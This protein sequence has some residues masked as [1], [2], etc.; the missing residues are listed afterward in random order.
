VK[1]KLLALAVSGVI[2]AGCNNDTNIKPNV[3][4]QAWDPAVYLMNAEANCTDG[5]IETGKTDFSGNAAFYSSTI[6]NSPET[7]SFTFTGDANS[8]DVSNGKSMD[9][10]TYVL[11]KGLAAAGAPITASPLTTLINTELKTTGAEYSDSAA[12][13]ILVDLGLTEILTSGVSVNDLLL[14]T[15][16]VTAKLKADASTNAS[17][18]YSLLSA[19]TAVLSDVL[20][21]SSGATVEQLTLTTNAISSDLLDDYETYPDNGGE[22]VVVTVSSEDVTIVLDQVKTDPAAEPN[23]PVQTPDKAEPV[24]PPKPPTGGTGGTGGGATGGKG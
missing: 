7:C 21:D 1:L 14:D 15:E 13:T 22:L 4:V 12:Q 24:D 9:G 19:T 8:V 11:P 6:V 20:K 5:T 3:A 10:V 18:S 23:V 16:T 17:S 2:L